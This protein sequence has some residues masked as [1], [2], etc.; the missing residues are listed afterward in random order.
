MFIARAHREEAVDK[1]DRMDDQA[2]AHGKNAT[3]QTENLEPEDWKIYEVG[4]A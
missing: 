4:T 2:E 3:D 1:E